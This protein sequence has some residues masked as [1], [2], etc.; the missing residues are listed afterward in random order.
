M[1]TTHCL[2]ALSAVHNYLTGLIRGMGL[3]I[4]LA[5]ELIIDSWVCIFYIAINIYKNSK[6]EQNTIAN[7]E[8]R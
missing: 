4:L 6:R 1:K 7:A 3:Q 2:N 5:D 8:G